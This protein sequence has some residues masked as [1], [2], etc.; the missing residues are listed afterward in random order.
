M[1]TEEPQI[2]ED[3]LVAVIAYLCTKRGWITK[4]QASKLPYLV[5]VVAQHVL[6]RRITSASHQQWREG[7]V[8]AEVWHYF[9]LG[10]QGIFSVKKVPNADRAV[11]ISVGQ[12]VIIP[13]LEPEELEIVNYVSEEFGSLNYEQLGALTKA[14]NIEVPSSSWQGN[15]AAKV[16][17]DSYVRLIGRWDIML[18]TLALN[19][20]EDEEKWGELTGASIDDLRKSLGV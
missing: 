7:V 9:K 19:D 5:D 2:L 15:G 12:D 13:N 6:G 20:T 18:E 1:S 11:Q 3:K 4:T 17:E 10:A 14:M 16:D 8:A